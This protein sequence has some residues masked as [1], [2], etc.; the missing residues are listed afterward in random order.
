[1][2]N[3]ACGEHR[4]LNETFALLGRLTGYQRAAV[5]QEARSGDVRNSLADI[6]AAREALGYE[7][8]VD[9]VEG[10]ERTVAWY[11]EQRKATL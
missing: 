3:I 9:F 2:F 1:V 6:S 11:R 10:M 8:A 4:T 7:P 5:H